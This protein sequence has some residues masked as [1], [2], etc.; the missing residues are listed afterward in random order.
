MDFVSLIESDWPRERSAGSWTETIH[1]LI[2]VLET[3]HTGI[4]V[5]CN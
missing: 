1:A 3:G 5:D 4:S 2:V